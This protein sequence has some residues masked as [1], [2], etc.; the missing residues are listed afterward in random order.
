[1]YYF[2]CN[3][4]LQMGLIY[5]EQKQYAKAREYLT[6]CLSL[7]PSEY[8]N[9]LHQKAKTVLDRIKGKKG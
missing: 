9:S 5:E 3:A 6:V 4:A 7:S 1:M 2:A 8:K